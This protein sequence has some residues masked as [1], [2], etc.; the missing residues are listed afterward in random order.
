MTKKCQSF[1]CGDALCFCVHCG[2]VVSAH[3]KDLALI[4]SQACTDTHPTKRNVL[5]VANMGLW[6]NED[7][8]EPHFMCLYHR[9]IF[10][11]MRK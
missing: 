7:N 4:K 11:V 8:G 3:L 1:N 5:L 10:S 2:V 9:A 6:Y